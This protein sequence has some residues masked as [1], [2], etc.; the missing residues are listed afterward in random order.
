[1]SAFSGFYHLGYVTNDLDRA[2]ASF[3]SQYGTA[4]F[5]EIGQRSF[6]L[7]GIAQVELRVAMCFVDRT[8]LE[9]IQPLGG[10]DGVYR[11]ALAGTGYQL[12]FHHTC[13]KVESIATLEEK[14]RSLVASGHK[15]VLS[16]GDH[17]N[18]SYF[19]ADAT[20]GLGHHLEYLYLS[21]SRAAFHAALPSN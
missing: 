9:I 14:R 12:R 8:Q 20:D 18:A 16:G 4:R 5:S 1:M 10:E 6:K 3:G 7:D 2:L 13:F 19:Y 15:I 17:E 21:P 11:R